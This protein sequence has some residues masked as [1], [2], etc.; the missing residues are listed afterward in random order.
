[1]GHR[2]A[3]ASSPRTTAKTSHAL[4]GEVAHSLNLHIHADQSKY[5]GACSRLQC[6]IIKT[7]SARKEWA[8]LDR[9]LEYARG[10]E[11]GEGDGL[12]AAVVWIEAAQE[13]VHHGSLG[14]AG[15]A[16]QE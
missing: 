6:Y 3:L 10:G 16:H 1:M 14:R 12:G 5:E 7:R 4:A 2:C 11:V 8:H 13:L 15:A 9:V